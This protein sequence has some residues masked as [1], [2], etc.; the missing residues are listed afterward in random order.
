MQASRDR[1][2]AT[3]LLE[4]IEPD[5]DD[6]FVRQPSVPWRP[7]QTHLHADI[8]AWRELKQRACAWPAQSDAC[9]FR[10]PSLEISRT[11]LR[12]EHDYT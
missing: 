1:P 7:G 6:G 10:G 3:D 9:R 8:R 5:D 11:T 4:T 2:H 12:D